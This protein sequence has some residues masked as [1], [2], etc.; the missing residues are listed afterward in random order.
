ML[1]L[2]L[3]ESLLESDYI[4]I[5]DSISKVIIKFLP[6]LIQSFFERLVQKAK[7]SKRIGTAFARL[8][9]KILYY[10]K[11]LIYFYLK[12]LEFCLTLEP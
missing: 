3:T 7:N 4:L 5:L 6:Y 11:L 9:A 10:L 8:I 2:N 1:L 12:F